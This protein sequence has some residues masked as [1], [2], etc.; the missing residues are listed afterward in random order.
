MAAIIGLLFI[1][2]V[3]VVTVRIGAIALELTGLSFEVAVFQSQSAFFGA[4]F[5]TSESEYIVNHSVR[6]KI[7]RLLILVGNVG[8]VSSG[9]TLIVA[10]SGFTDTNAGIRAPLLAGSLVL[11]ILVSRSTVVY[12]LMKKVIVSVLKRNRSLRLTDYHDILGISK[13]YSI[14]QMRVKNNSWQKGRSLKELGLRK[15]GTIILAIRRK[16]ENEEII[17][18]PHGGI[19]IEEDDLLTVYGRDEAVN[20]LFTR[21]AGAEGDEIH[22][23][24]VDQGNALRE[25]GN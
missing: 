3:S 20:C 13:G 4:G 14:S 18:M 1:L 7:I 9:A 16:V 19:V 25:L 24:R 22:R 8:M 23:I 11:V 5:T 6:R 15:E 21:P 12:R 10:L 2:G 17:V